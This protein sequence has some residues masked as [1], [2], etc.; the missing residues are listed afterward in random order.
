MSPA[1][2]QDMIQRYG[3]WSQRAGEKGKLKGGEKLRDREGRVA[4]G[5]AGGMKVTDGP[6]AESKEI[7]GGYWV[8]EAAGYDEVQQLIADHPHLE[9]GSLEIREIED[10]GRP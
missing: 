5:D 2:M 4:R 7:I 3:A 10:I 1:Q 9:F 8:L 6:F